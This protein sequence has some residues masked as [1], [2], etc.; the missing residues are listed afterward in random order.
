MLFDDS[1][2][3]VV[4]DPG[5]FSR[6]EEEEIKD[7]ILSNS[8]NIEFILNTHCHIDHV[9]GNAFLCNSLNLKPQIHE[10]DLVIL[11]SVSAYGEAFGIKATESPQPEKFLKEGDEI[12]FGNSLLSVLHVPG[13]SP[14]HVVFVNHKQK[15]IIGGDVLFYGSIGRTDLPY[16]DHDT[17]ISQIRKKLLTM[18]PDFKVYPGHGPVTTI[19][20]EKAN[21]PFLQ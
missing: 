4:I 19:G 20:F 17:L 12:K 5:C 8:L 11:N 9:L 18:D 16:G 15:F 3:A 21:N 6:K 13:H 1:L 10:D 14:G 7:F 2:A